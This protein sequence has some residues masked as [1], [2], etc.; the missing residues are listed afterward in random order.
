[1]M[2]YLATEF[3]VSFTMMGYGREGIVRYRLVG[4][5]LIVHGG[6]R[7]GAIDTDIRSSHSATNAGKVGTVLQL[8]LV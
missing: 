6:I 3:I 5:Q 2:E 1:M 4:S 8:D 7:L